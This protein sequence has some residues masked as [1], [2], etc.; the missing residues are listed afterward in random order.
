MRVSGRSPESAGNNFLAAPVH[1]IGFDIVESVVEGC[2]GQPELVILVD[3]TPLFGPEGEVMGVD[4][5]ELFGPGNPLVPT[6]GGRSVVVRDE[7]YWGQSDSVEV[8]IR[9][10]GSRVVWQVWQRSDRG[11]PPLV[12]DHG[13]YLEALDR[14]DRERPVSYC[15]AASDR[16]AALLAGRPDVIARFGYR[17]D[18]V[19]VHTPGGVPI[20]QVRV[21]VSKGRWPRHT[22]TIT[23]QVPDAAASPDQAAQ[24]MFERLTGFPL[25]AQVNRAI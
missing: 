20:G 14:F 13:Q 21:E 16:F 6:P 1:R 8:L 12:F 15:R 9:L 25:W 23:V 18:A 5:D 7:P 10:L 22:H 19:V 24:Q 3:G 11:T 4:P 2:E 17:I